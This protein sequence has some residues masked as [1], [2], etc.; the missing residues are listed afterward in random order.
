MKHEKFIKY[1]SIG[2]Y[3]IQLGTFLGS[4]I[5]YVTNKNK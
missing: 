4:V 3:L 2:Y 1:T 5:Y